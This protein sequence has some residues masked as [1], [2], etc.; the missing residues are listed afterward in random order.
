M[1]MAASQAR[2]LCITARIHDVE[3]QAQSIQNAKMQLANLSDQAYQDY[4]NELDST[5]L[6][7]K[8]LDNGA[9]STIAANFRNLCSRNRVK[10]ADDGNVYAIRDKKGLLLV[11]NEVYSAYNTF[12]NL[13]CSQDAYAFAM[14]MVSGDT[15]NSF[16]D[17]ENTT[18]GLSNIDKGLRKG[19]EA[20]YQKQLTENGTDTILHSRRQ[21]ILDIISRASEKSDKQPLPDDIY[22]VN[23]IVSESNDN[24]LKNN[25]RNALMSYKEELYRL[26]ASTVLANCDE[27]SSNVES[28]YDNTS[29]KDFDQEGFDYY[30][31]I[32]KQIQ[33][34]GGCRPISDY[35]GFDGD[36]SNDGDWLQA[37]IKCGELTID[38][39]KTDKTS[40]KV[41]LIATSPSTD[42]SLGYTQTTELDKKALLKAEAKYEKSLKEINQKDKQYDLT[43][44][45]L[46]TERTTLTTQYESVQ[47]VIKENIERT[48]GIF[49]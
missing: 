42:I 14:Y 23:G 21:S 13:G 34:S 49:S 33:A 37:M 4:L 16:S 24:E 38:I 40:G 9:E 44:S 30:L 47:K 26:E 20:A 29:A 10:S 19:E 48:F 7:I 2:L 39:A 12:K 1:G 3:Y 41:D 36:A 18:S 11:D 43:L 5:T 32:Y 25:Y 22:D 27:A 15:A 6:T 31:D 28:S 45:K 46:D 35:D 17:V 8:S